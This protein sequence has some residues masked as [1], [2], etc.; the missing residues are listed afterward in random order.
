MGK[1]ELSELGLKDR[2]AWEAAGYALPQYDREAMIAQTKAAPTWLHFGAGNIFKAFQANAAQKL[3]NQ[4]I[5]QTGIIAV[6]RTKRG[7]DSHDGYTVL[8][9]LK[10]DGQVEKTVIG[11]IAETCYLY[12]GEERLEEIFKAPSLQMVS[13]TITE[14]GYSL[15]D[16]KGEMLPDVAEDLA[17]GPAAPKSFFD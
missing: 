12:G 15:V 11:S 17:N 4:G 1:L 5:F 13:F 14:K 10:A 6:E 2:A 9:T 16:G 7:E 3:L 8:V